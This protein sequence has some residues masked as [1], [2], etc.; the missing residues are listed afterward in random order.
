MITFE[1]LK[2][3]LI[4]SE[5]EIQSDNE[6]LSGEEYAEIMTWFST[7]INDAKTLLDIVRVYENKSGFE[8]F[9]AFAYVIN[10]LM[11]TATVD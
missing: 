5:V 6:S 4:Q 7:D 3:V 8:T 9:D 1:Q 11:A 10:T 2:E